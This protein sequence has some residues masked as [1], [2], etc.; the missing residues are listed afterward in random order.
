M[1]DEL[2]VRLEEANQG[3]QRLKKINAMLEELEEQKYELINK[4]QELEV[5]LQREDGDVE[6]LEGKSLAHIFH[7]MLGNLE[8]QLNKERQEAL[9]AQL[10]YNQAVNERKHVES[11]IEQLKAES[12]RYRLCESTYKQLYQ[13]KKEMLM[14]TASE[15]AERILELSQQITILQSQRKEI[16][17]AVRA[18]NNALKHL[19]NACASLNSAEGWGTWDLLGG[20]LI[21]DLAKHSHIDDAKSEVEEAQESLSDF[22]TELA[23]VKIV[24]SISIETE[25]FAKFADFFFDGLIADWCMQSK[26]HDSQDGVNQTIAEVQKVLDRLEVLDKEEALQQKALEREMGERITS[27]R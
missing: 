3:L 18:G 25:G 6:R 7:A 2:N 5:I 24:S 26:I 15:Q 23:D 14:Q 11:V 8:G 17:E 9:A 21:S 12:S 27:A 22:R 13:R 4:E 20:G 10:K 1:F 16:G 19:K